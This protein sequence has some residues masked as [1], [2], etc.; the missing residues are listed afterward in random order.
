MCRATHVLFTDSN[1]KRTTVFFL[2]NQSTRL[3]PGMGKYTCLLYV[4]IWELMNQSMGLKEQQC[5][6]G[7]GDNHHHHHHNIKMVSLSLEYSLPHQN[8][9]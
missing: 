4:S 5:N 8:I 9:N 3:V 2:A 6:G 1:F 7:D